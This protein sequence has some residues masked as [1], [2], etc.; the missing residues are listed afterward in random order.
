M[1]MDRTLAFLLLVSLLPSHVNAGGSS[2]RFQPKEA[3]RPDLDGGAY[4]EYAMNIDVQRLFHDST[5]REGIIS[6]SDFFVDGNVPSSIEVQFFSDEEPKTFQKVMG[7]NRDADT[8]YWYGEES[9][10][11]ESS[12]NLIAKTD[13]TN[14]LR[15]T[16]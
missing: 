15:I 13:D 12:L 6:L 11:N 2:A 5:L 3:N 1:K 4:D 10:K 16:G 7:H 14:M 9:D 8:Y